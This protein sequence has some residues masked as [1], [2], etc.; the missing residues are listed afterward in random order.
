MPGITRRNDTAGGVITNT[1]TTVRAN[2]RFVI[3]NG[4]PVA[5]HGVGPHVSATMIADTKNVFIGGKAVVN[6]GDLA[7]CGDPATGSDDVRVGNP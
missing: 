3:V 1:Q 4:D 7:T 2:G 5:P 6:A